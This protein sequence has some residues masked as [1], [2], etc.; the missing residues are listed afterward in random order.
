MFT[1]SFWT[2]AL[3]RALKTAAQFVLVGA[4]GDMVSAWSMDWKAIT[5]AAAAGFVLSMLTSLASI[6]F[7]EPGNPS[8]VAEDRESGLL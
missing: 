6:P 7:A 8:L 4:G 5:G 2:Q 3:E 1:T